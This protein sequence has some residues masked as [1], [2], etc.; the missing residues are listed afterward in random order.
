MSQEFLRAALQTFSKKR[1][2]ILLD[3]AGIMIAVATAM[4]IGLWIHEILIK[5]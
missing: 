4:L 5:R 1:L 3:I 2:S